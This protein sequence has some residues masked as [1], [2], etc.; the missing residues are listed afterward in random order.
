MLRDVECPYCGTGLYINHDDGFGYE[1]EVLHEYECPHCGKLFVF[2]TFVSFDYEAH[3]A[4][5]LNGKPHNFKPTVTFPAEATMMEC[6][7]CGLK[8]KPTEKEMGNILKQTKNINLDARDLEELIN[9]MIVSP[10]DLETHWNM[11]IKLVE[12][13][14]NM[15]SEIMRL[16]KA[17]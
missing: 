6:V 15:Q 9:G 5:C 4:D 11:T 16:S 14:Q 1:E 13:V 12:I 2:E 17:G 7:D 10:I 3:K 8:R